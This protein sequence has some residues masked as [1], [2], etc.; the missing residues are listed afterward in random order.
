MLLPDIALV[1]GRVM[2]AAWEFGLDTIEDDVIHLMMIAIE[3]NASS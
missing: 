3:V 1:N 2:V